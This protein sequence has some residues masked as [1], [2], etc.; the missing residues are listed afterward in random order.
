MNKYNALKGD[1]TIFFMIDRN[2]NNQKQIRFSLWLTILYVIV[3]VVGILRHEMW[4]DE[5]QT[6]LV[7]SQSHSLLD[8]WRNSQYEGHALLW[9]FFLF[10][11]SRFTQDLLAMQLFH[12]AMAAI[13]VF[14]IAEFSPFTKFQKFLLSFGYFFLYEY[15]VISRYYVLTV[16]LLFI[17]LTL[18]NSVQRR[19]IIFSIIL[20]LL[21]NTSLFGAVFSI[22][23]LFLVIYRFKTDQ[24]KKPF[25]TIWNWR[26]VLAV[27]IFFLGI[28]FSLYSI[29]R[30]AHSTFAQTSF[31][32]HGGFDSERL[33]LTLSKILAAFIPIPN[34][35]EQNFWNT[36]I[37]FDVPWEIRVILVAGIVVFI[38]LNFRKNK[39]VF[40]FWGCGVFSIGTLVYLLLIPAIRY[41]GHI[42]LLLVASLWLNALLS[43]RETRP[44]TKK[45][46]RTL[47]SS[48]SFVFHFILLLQVV[49]GCTAY[50]QHI[51]FPFSN[52]GEAGRYL[53]REDL[54]RQYLFG[55]LDFIV[56]PLSAFVHRPIY[57]PERDSVGTYIVSD[58]RRK[59]FPPMQEVVQK[60]IGLVHTT[61]DSMVMIL[62]GPIT[63][64]QNNRIVEIVDRQ[65]PGGVHL[66]L[67]QKFNTP[68]I[69][70]DE[71]Y[72]IYQL[73]RTNEK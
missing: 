5:F 20:F 43:N 17:A 41:E 32:W 51:R 34:T 24:Q 57:Y 4:R 56:S 38:S 54:S 30:G 22:L 11:I 52:C 25:S 46:R 8:L 26:P 59:Q 50:V 67:L 42:F 73:S 37:V 63:Y 23:L 36:S 13:A 40:L 69:A 39:S 1:R 21:A 28:I 2:V 10:I 65:L 6:W 35:L 29:Q 7:A 55:S 18:F 64:S 12:I 60:A 68:C 48:T 71:T 53:A 9:H 66:T 61:C 47:P 62:T 16:L 14:I 70:W 44:K 3:G 31:L 15:A 33:I 19:P 45:I 72:Y 49:A 58:D 27:G